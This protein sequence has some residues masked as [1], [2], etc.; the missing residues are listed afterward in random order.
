M[1][2]G[3]F[4]VAW[5]PCDA[6][7]H[8][9]DT[10]ISQ[11]SFKDQ[12]KNCAQCLCEPCVTD[13]WAC[14]KWLPCA[15]ILLSRNG[16]LVHSFFWVVFGEKKFNI[17]FWNHQRNGPFTQDLLSLNISIKLSRSLSNPC[18]ICVQSL[19]YPWPKT[20]YTLDKINVCLQK[21][22]HL[23]FII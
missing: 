11:G 17:I 5:N 10:K 2:F 1:S 16:I 21:K 6:S 9:Y 20:V 14:Q 23:S 8:N 15:F 12:M 19:Y 18:L 22:R 4:F 3:S 13:S 7:F